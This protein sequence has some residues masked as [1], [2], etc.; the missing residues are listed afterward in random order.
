SDNA[1]FRQSSALRHNADEASRYDRCGSPAVVRKRNAEGDGDIEPLIGVYLSD[2]EA[3][4]AIKRMKDKPGFA[5]FPQGFEMCPYS[6][7][8]DHWTDGFVLDGKRALPRWLA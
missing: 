5:D 2:E 1:C 3:R 4:A 6:L 8:R 7:N